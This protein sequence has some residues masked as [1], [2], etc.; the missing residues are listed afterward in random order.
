MSEKF[1]QL[2]DILGEVADLNAA[3]SLLG[4]DQQTYMPAG[5]NDARGQHLATLGKIAHEKA[6]SPRVGEL[7]GELKAEVTAADPGGDAADLI[8]VAARD[9]DKAVR[10]PSEFVAEQAIVTSTAFQAWNEA[11]AKS[12]FEI[13]RPHLEKVVALVKR[14]ITFFPPSEH[15]YDV[16]LDDYEP[17]MK[18]RRCQGYL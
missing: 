6:T 4:W 13:F 17:G 5:G 10:V 7:I 18:T 9:Y 12:D 14:Y 11:R 16:L 2:K 1:D 15:P 8:R 3:M